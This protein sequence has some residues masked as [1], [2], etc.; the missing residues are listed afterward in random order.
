[1]PHFIKQ[2]VLKLFWNISSLNREITPLLDLCF[3]RT[4]YETCPKNVLFFHRMCHFS[5]S[6]N[7]Q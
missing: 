5:N 4:A 2:Q 6:Y 1:M 3:V 7:L